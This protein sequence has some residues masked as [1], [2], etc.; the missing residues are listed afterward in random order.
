MPDAPGF[1]DP[2]LSAVPATGGV[3]VGLVVSLALAAIALAAA[4]VLF[5]RERRGFGR[6]CRCAGCRAL[7]R[8][9]V[10]PLRDDAN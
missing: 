2:S 6:V 9:R 7:S 10:R 8:D 3:D 4:I 5:V 1:G